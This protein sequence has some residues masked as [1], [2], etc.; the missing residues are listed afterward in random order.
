M[1]NFFICDFQFK[2][3]FNDFLNQK[4]SKSLINQGLLS[5]FLYSNCNSNS[6]TN[7]GVVTCTDETHHLCA[8]VNLEE[9][10]DII[11]PYKISLLNCKILASNTSYS[12]FL[13]T[14]YRVLMLLYTVFIKFSCNF[15]AN[16]LMHI[17]ATELM[18]DTMKIEFK[19][20]YLQHICGTRLVAQNVS[21]HLCCCQMGHASSKIIKKYYI[22]MSKHEPEIIKDNFEKI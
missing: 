7:H 18:C 12:V 11:R 10:Q 13:K 3:I 22:V 4:I 2:K 15:P 5:S 14:L 1:S 9:H 17:F 21:S 6:H 20:H 8:L 19:Y 16:Y